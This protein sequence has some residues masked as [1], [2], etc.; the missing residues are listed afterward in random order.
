MSIGL[1]TY[2]LTIQRPAVHS[3]ACHVKEEDRE[4]AAEWRAA[5]SKGEGRGEEGSFERRRRGMSSKLCKTLM[6]SPRALSAGFK[7]HRFGALTSLRK[8]QK[9]WVNCDKEIRAYD[10]L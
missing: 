7:I 3:A 8:S 4:A 1:S 10:L 9:K 6:P 5:L 2:S